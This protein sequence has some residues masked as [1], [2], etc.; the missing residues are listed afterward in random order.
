MYSSPDNIIA[1][2]TSVGWETD[3]SSYKPSFPMSLL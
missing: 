2:M 3:P 1:Q